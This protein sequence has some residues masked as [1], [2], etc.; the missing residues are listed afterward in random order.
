MVEWAGGWHLRESQAALA[1]ATSRRP[2]EEAQDK[3]MTTKKQKKNQ[4]IKYKSAIE[5]TYNKRYSYYGKALS[6]SIR[7][8]FFCHHFC[9]LFY[10]PFGC[11]RD[12][13]SSWHAVDEHVADVPC[14]GRFSSP[15]RHGIF[16]PIT[17]RIFVFYAVC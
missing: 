11:E 16:S 14:L 10:Y 13:L 5:Y 15:P 17:Y 8:D 6:S 12:S 2:T 3:R 7:S 1:A 9:F 4:R